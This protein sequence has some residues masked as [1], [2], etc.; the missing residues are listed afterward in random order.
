MVGHLNSAG[1]AQR[2]A[3]SV[4]FKLMDNH[5]VSAHILNKL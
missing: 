2:Q 4:N 3:R 1:T 5:Q